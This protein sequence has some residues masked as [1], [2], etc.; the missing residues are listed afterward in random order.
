MAKL[1]KTIENVI[2][3]GRRKG[4]PEIHK[5]NPNTCIHP[6]ARVMF[7]IIHPRVKYPILKIPLSQ[8]KIRITQEKIG[9]MNISVIA[10]TRVKGLFS[11]YIGI[12][13]M[14]IH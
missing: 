5:V 2:E 8:K 6:I 13:P 10:K 7:P 1:K 3:I 11:E 4:C 9:A 12:K 14:P